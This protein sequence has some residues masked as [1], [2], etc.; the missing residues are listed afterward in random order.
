MAIVMITAILVF[1]IG[2]SP[3][4][5]HTLSDSRKKAYRIS[6]GYAGKSV[7]VTARTPQKAVEKFYR[8]Y[9][10]WTIYKIEEMDW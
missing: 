3:V 8:E 2:I 6:Y 4:I 1:I 7:F 10:H 5:F 9:G